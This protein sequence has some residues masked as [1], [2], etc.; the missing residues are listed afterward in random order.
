MEVSGF[1]LRSNP[2][3]QDSRGC[4]RQEIREI[5][6]IGVAAASGVSYKFAGRR[7]AGGE[8]PEIFPG[9]TPEPVAEL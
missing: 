4:L 5:V 9:L 7:G 1:W 3:G 2:R 6:K 8:S